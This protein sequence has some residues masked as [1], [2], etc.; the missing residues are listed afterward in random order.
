MNSRS[1][2]GSHHRRWPL[3]AVSALRAIYCPS[4]GIVATAAGLWAGSLVPGP[5]ELAVWI[6]V[7]A[8]L[9]VIAI[10]LC[11][12]AAVTL[13]RFMNKHVKERKRDCST[14]GKKTFP[15][16]PPRTPA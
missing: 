11:D 10:L 8:L 6:S 15:I 4:A 3:S 7:T 9:S 12:P 13:G 16:P 1:A 5:D 2:A 14:S